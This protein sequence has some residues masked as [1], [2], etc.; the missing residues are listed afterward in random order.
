MQARQLLR[1][2]ELGGVAEL[3]RQSGPGLAQATNASLRLFPQLETASRCV[4]ENLVPAGNVVIDDNGGAY[5]STLVTN[6]PN[7]REFF[8]STV[9]LAGESQNFDGNGPYVRFQAGGGPELVRMAMPGAAALNTAVWGHNISPPLGIRP[10]LPAGGKPPFRM[11]VPCYTQAVPDI[12]GP[13]AD[14]GPP[15]TEVVP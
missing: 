3:L 10:A 9:G 2:G 13:A 7:F 6:Q 15:S 8:Y 5:P 4:S 11:D 1:K 12:N 14:T